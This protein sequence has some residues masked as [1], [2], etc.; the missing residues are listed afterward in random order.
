MYPS[1][2]IRVSLNPDP[3]LFGAECFSTADVEHIGDL[4]T[5]IL[6]CFQGMNDYKYNLRYFPGNKVAL[7]VGGIFTENPEFGPNPEPDPLYGVFADVIQQFNWSNPQ[8][9]LDRRFWVCSVNLL[10]VEASKTMLNASE[11]T[12]VNNIWCDCYTNRLP[13][14]TV[15]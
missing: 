8:N 6:E 14:R 2:A 9:P 13:F 15:L 10:G 7:Y 12:K 1:T 11:V 5:K 4:G 3:R